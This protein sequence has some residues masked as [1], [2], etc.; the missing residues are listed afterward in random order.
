MRSSY[1]TLTRAAGS[2]ISRQNRSHFCVIGN[3]CTCN[4]GD[5]KMRSPF[6]MHHCD[7]KICQM[8][9]VS[10]RS[11][12]LYIVVVIKNS[13][14][15]KNTLSFDLNKKWLMTKKWSEKLIHNSFQFRRFVLASSKT[16]LDQDNVK[17][18]RI[19]KISP[20]QNRF[21]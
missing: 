17:I 14:N 7:I 21:L 13:S 20:A 12:L 8:H 10:N 6:F 1:G 3:Q 4:Q 16:T 5:I 19:E 2:F 18:W 15:Y 11:R 9:I